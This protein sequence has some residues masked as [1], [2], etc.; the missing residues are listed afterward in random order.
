MLNNR[1]LRAGDPKAEELARFLN[2]AQ[3]EEAFRVREV[4]KYCRELD[5]IRSKGAGTKTAGLRRGVNAHLL[6][7]A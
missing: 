6:N 1:L 7:I 4:F 5:A 3:G 2:V